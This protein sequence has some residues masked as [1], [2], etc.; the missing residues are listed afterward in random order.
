MMFLRFPVGLRGASPRLESYINS[1]FRSEPLDQTSTIFLSCF[2]VMASSALLDHNTAKSLLQPSGQDH[3]QAEE[4]HH[5]W[6]TEPSHHRD[7]QLA[8][9]FSEHSSIYKALEDKP[10][11]RVWDSM[12]GSIPDPLRENRM[13]ARLPR[14]E[15]ATKDARKT[16]LATHV[17]HGIWK[18]TPYI[19]FTSR[20]DAAN[21]T[22]KYRQP[23]RGDQHL[24]AIDPRHRLRQG[25]PILDIKEEMAAYGVENPYKYDYFSDHYLCLWEVTPAEVVG[26]WSWNELQKDTNWYENIIMP[27]FEKHRT[28]GHSA[29]QTATRDVDALSSILAGTYIDGELKFY[30]LP[31]S[32][33]TNCCTQDTGRRFKDPS[34][35]RYDDFSD[36]E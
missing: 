6:L 19:S 3:F 18:D 27:A 21:G 25:L 14:G 11:L 2:D 13:L 8:N 36:S 28:A 9:P 29:V 31:L 7:G 26:S 5:P 32:L 4:K 34:D 30:D 17:D 10:L 23:R 20:P 35:P 24:V 22:A 15:L 1:T 12:S 33:L 16:S